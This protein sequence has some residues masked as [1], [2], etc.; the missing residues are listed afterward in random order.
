M[1]DRIAWDLNFDYEIYVAPGNTFGQLNDDGGWDGIM[2]ELI[3]KNADIGL[4]TLSV[5]AERE[6]VIDFTVPIYDMVGMQILMKKRMLSTS[7]VSFVTVLENEVWVS[8][9]AAYLCT[10]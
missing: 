4:G 1:L 6:N 5:M 10:R 9:I 2:K 3:E 8:I 7:L